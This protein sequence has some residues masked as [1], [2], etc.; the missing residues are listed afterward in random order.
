[1]RWFTGNI[2]YHHVHHLNSLIPFYQ[3]PEA[4]SAVPELQRPIVTSLNP[5]DIVACLRLNLWDWQKQEL[6]GYK[7]A[8]LTPRQSQSTCLQAGEQ[9][10]RQH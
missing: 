1:M 4:M 2:G 5:R 9:A 7:D 10:L 3:L 6:V 8:I